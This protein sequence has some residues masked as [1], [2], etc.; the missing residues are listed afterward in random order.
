MATEMSSLPRIPQSPLASVSALS[1]LSGMTAPSRTSRNATS[2]TA[3]PQQMG[4]IINLINKATENPMYVLG[5]VL[6]VCLI[7]VALIFH[8]GYHKLAM[9][10]IMIGVV[11]AIFAAILYFF[12]KYI[13]YL[14]L[15]FTALAPIAFAFIVYFLTEMCN[16]VDND[17]SN[18]STSTIS[19]VMYTIGFLGIILYLYGK[20]NIA[21]LFLIMLL[22]FLII[23][24][25]QTGISTYNGIAYG[26]GLLIF[27]IGY[28]IY[29]NRNNPM[30]GVTI[31]TRWQDW[32]LIAVPFIVVIATEILIL[33]KAE[34]YPKLW[35]IVI[36]LM[37]ILFVYAAYK[38]YKYYRKNFYRD[39]S[40]NTSR[41]VEMTNRSS[42]RRSTNTQNVARTM[43][44]NAGIS[45]PSRFVSQLASINRATRNQ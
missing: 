21:I 4:Y 29:S 35:I 23:K 31:P 37:I 2:A 15:G 11:T 5:G 8:W 34:Q 10:I 45:N 30:W 18:S 13:M 24:G 14:I 28:R 7:T 12:G 36:I 9:F 39:T 44:R 22:T 38:A 6:F 26:L 3:E 16:A 17:N 43:A 33:L 19:I 1:A 40:R 27:I 25:K 41:N 32:M 42:T 20:Y